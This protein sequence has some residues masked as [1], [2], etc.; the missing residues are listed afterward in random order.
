MA[1]SKSSHKPSAQ[2]SSEGRRIRNFPKHTLEEA[3][4]LPQK[5]QDEMG[6]MPMNRLLL[7]DALGLVLVAVIFGIY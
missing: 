7:A 5:I 2:N 6:G 1:K 3:L 4:V